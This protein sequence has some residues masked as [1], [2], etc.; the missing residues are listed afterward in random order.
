MPGIDQGFVGQLEQ[1]VEQRIIRVVRVAVLEIGA[2]GAPDKQRVAG[3]HAIVREETV[4][5]VGVPR[6][7]DDIKGNGFDLDLVALVDA[8]GNDVDL[9]V[10]SHH[11]DAARPVAKGPEPGDMVGVYMGI[12]G[13]DEFQV[14]FVQQPDVVVDRFEDGVDDQHLT[15]R[16]AAEQI[17]VSARD[18]LEDLAKDHDDSECRCGSIGDG[19]S[20][21]SGAGRSP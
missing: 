15:A 4:R 2:A 5:I 20:G 1:L 14:Q 10:P 6:R 18:G 3:K 17:G 16:A 11:G 9:A 8:H 21:R 7:V 12:H 13:L 19:S